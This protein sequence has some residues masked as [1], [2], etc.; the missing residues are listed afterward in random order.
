VEDG[1][2]GLLA[3]DL[4]LQAW[5]RLLQRLEVGEDELGDDRLDV[6]RRG[7]LPLDVD[8]VRVAERAGDEAD[9]VR[10]AD[11]REELVAQALALGGAADDPRDVD[12][13]HRRGEDLLRAEDLGELLQPWVRQRHD[14]DVRLDRRERVVRGEHGRA[15]QRVEEGRLADV[16]QSRDSDGE[17]HGT[18][19]YVAPP[20]PRRCGS[21]PSRVPCPTPA[22][23]AGTR[24]P[25]SATGD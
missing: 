24:W 13:G 16:R 2:V 12:E 11:V 4:L 23:P 10:L 3:A 6:V 7:H 22:G 9:R 18:R 19:V 17:G 1:G 15:R 14:A 5:D 20:G 25:G 21:S 8:D